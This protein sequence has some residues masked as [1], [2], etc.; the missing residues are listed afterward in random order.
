MEIKLLKLML[1]SGESR[2]VNPRSSVG[3]TDLLGFDPLEQ[4]LNLPMLAYYP[5]TLEKTSADA[6]V[7][8]I[9]GKKKCYINTAHIVDAELVTPDEAYAYGFGE[10]KY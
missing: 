6:P 8:L 2:L 4:P 9:M 7:Q 10:Q 1:I 5:C 3:L